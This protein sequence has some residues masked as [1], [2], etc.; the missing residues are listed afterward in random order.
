VGEGTELSSPPMAHP[1]RAHWTLD[2]GIRFLN[3]GSFGACPRPILEAQSEWRAR[4]EREPVLFLARQL[5]DLV[6]TARESLARF[7]HASSEDL[8]PVT[9]ATT[10]VNAVLRSLRLQPGDELLVTDHGHNACRNVVDHVAEQ[11]GARVVVAAVPFPIAGPEAVLEA[12]L[13]RVSARTRLAL[14]DHVTSPTGLVFP[15]ERLVSELAE[16]GVDVMIDGAHAPGMLALDLEALGAAY[17][18]GNLHKWVSAPKG[19]AFL[20]VRRDRQAGLRPPVI[21]HGANAVRSDRSRFR[22]EFDY[23][24]T[25]DPTAFLVVPDCL[26]FLGGLYPGGW[27]EL[28]S[29]CHQ[30]VLQGRELLLEALGA[31][32]PAPESMLGTLAAVPLPLQGAPGGDIFSGDPLQRA[33]FERHFELP[34]YHW[35]APRLRVLRISA[36][37]YN[38]LDEYRLLAQAVA[39]LV[40]RS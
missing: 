3:H 23:M 30:L 1:L 39:E 26:S 6:D 24:G 32:A 34:V 16:R 36:W 18:T 31:E 11:G 29:R 37:A 13:A 8:V 21:S 10:G 27:E 22:L 5:G 20:Y 28:R 19:A 14:L 12:V 40:G 35:A 33:L 17:Y 38:E 2:P 9:N 4:M 25:D 7:V 15:V